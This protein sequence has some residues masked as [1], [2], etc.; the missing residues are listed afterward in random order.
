MAG[1]VELPDGRALTPAAPALWDST[2]QLGEQFLNEIIAHPVPLD[3]RILRPRRLRPPFENVIA[4]NH[5]SNSTSAFKNSFH[6]SWRLDLP[7]GA[8]GRS[9]TDSCARAP[10]YC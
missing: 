1:A 5:R 8:P 7:R 6:V 4:W 9:R 10:T 3:L 2:I